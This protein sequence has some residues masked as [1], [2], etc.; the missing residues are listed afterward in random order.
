MLLSQTAI[1]EAT[2]FSRWGGRKRGSGD[3]AGTDRVLVEPAE[4]G[5]ESIR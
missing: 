3:G 1:E 2:V 4:C 5:G